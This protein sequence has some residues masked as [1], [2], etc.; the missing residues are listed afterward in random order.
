[1]EYISTKETA[2]KWGVSVRNVQRLLT[3]NRIHGARKFSGSWFIP[4]DAEKP[5]D[6]RRG[7]KNAARPFYTFP[8]KCPLLSMTDLFSAYGGADEAV[9]SLADD[10]DAQTVFCAGLVYLR[11]DISGTSELL[12]TV[13][14]DET[15]PD[16]VIAIAFI[17]CLCALYKGDTQEWLFYKNKL[18]NMPCFTER[19]KA[20]RD[21]W[22]GAIDMGLYDDSGLPDWFKRGE[23]GLLPMDSY[24]MVRYVYI[25]YL[26]LSHKSAQL[27][28][29]I[30]P[31]V[32]ECH[33][34]G[35]VVAEIYCRLIVA[36]CYIEHGD[37]PAASEQLD[38]AI[39]LALPDRL[40]APFAEYRDN[41][42]TLLDERL[43]AVDKDILKLV[44]ALN[45]QVR[46]GWAN[47]NRELRGIVNTTDLT[48]QER[49]AAKFAAMGLTNA[50]IAKRMR[51]SVHTV[52][53]YISGAIEKTGAKNRTELAK[54]IAME[55]HNK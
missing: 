5:A 46:T 24:P 43:S 30:S 49:Q 37:I 36:V 55:A 1:M 45:E 19:E 18:K 12:D 2:E 20:Q 41:M 22:L 21:F 15:R 48:Q 10:R 40:F 11:G 8:R 34:E 9:S 16:I 29:L 53:R 33:A 44:K 23:F 42:S 26:E 3:E 51:L 27:P 39:A 32:S 25:V 7:R 6:P 50:E 31:F 52:K 35:A 17:R 38:A 13:C 47:I 4:A 28:L 14:F 54:Y